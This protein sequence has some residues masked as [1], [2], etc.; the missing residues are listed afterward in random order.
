MSCTHPMALAAA[1]LDT[2]VVAAGEEQQGAQVGEREGVSW[3]PFQH[4]PVH[5]LR[6]LQCT[7]RKK[8]QEGHRNSIVLLAG[9]KIS[10]VTSEY[11]T[12][13]IQVPN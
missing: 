7:V 9:G 8:S 10:F 4:A 11:R 3:I 6:S 13:T 5:G 12:S 1:S 2:F